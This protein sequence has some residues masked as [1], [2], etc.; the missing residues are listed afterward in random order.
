MRRFFVRR[1]FEP[2]G[3][4]HRR[5][6]TLLTPRDFDLSPYFEPVK[7]NAVAD[8]AFDYQQIQWADDEEA[9]AHRI[10]EIALGASQGGPSDPESH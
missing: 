2:Q 8:G 9:A 4:F 1:G 5:H 6:P 7:F 3:I 10:A